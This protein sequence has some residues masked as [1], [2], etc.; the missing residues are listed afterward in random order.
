[1][2]DHAPRGPAVPEG[3]IVGLQMSDGVYFVPPGRVWPYAVEPIR[4]RKPNEQQGPSGTLPTRSDT[5]IHV[6]IFPTSA[7]GASYAARALAAS[8]VED[9]Q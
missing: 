1:M 6:W 8:D 4:K 7:P 2:I 5:D 3:L 9:S